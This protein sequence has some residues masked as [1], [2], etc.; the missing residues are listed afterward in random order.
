MINDRINKPT[1][2]SVG[3][4][5]RAPINMTGTINIAINFMNNKIHPFQIKKAS[6]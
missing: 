3:L 4:I 2:I 6:R 1:P 5:N